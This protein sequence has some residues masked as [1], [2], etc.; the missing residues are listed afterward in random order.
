LRS[1]DNE[2]RFTSTRR[3]L[4]DCLLPSIPWIFLKFHTSC[5]QKF[6]CM[7]VSNGRIF[8]THNIS[9][10]P[11]VLQL[12]KLGC[13]WM[14]MRGPLPFFY[15]LVS[16]LGVFLKLC[17]SKIPWIRCKCLQFSCEW[18]ITKGALP[19]E[20]STFSSLSW[21]PFVQFSWTFIPCTTNPYPKNCVHFLVIGQT[22]INNWAAKYFSSYL[23]FQWRKFRTS[24]FP[25]IQ[26]K[27]DNFGSDQSI[28]K[29]N[30]LREQST[31]SSASLLPFEGFSWNFK[32]CRVHAYTAND[33]NVLAISQ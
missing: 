3:C 11:L 2:G 29:G 20:Q 5:C 15:I 9:Q 24:E 6:V 22:L 8:L 7:S 28:M 21:H 16:I 4:F 17:V 23:R 31:F 33:V 27:P 30:L 12:C 32:P 1:V 18:S 19:G 26:E 14:L 13:G 25:H 10:F